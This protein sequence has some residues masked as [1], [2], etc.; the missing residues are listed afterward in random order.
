MGFRVWRVPGQVLASLGMLTAVGC[1]L[2]SG[3]SRL[4]EVQCPEVCDS[5]GSQGD[6]A[7]EST[8]DGADETIVGDS[9]G[10]VDSGGLADRGEVADSAEDAGIADVSSELADASPDGRLVDAGS[11][12]AR[13]DGGDSSDGSSCRTDLSNIGTADFDIALT[14][15]TTQTGLVALVNQRQ[16]CGSYNYWWDLRIKNG[17]ILVETEAVNLTSTAI[18]NDGT[19]HKVSVQRTNGRVWIYIDGLLST[20]A[21]L[22]SSIGQLPPLVVGTDPC[23]STTAPFAGKVADLC[24]SSP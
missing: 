3:L 14:V 2:A 17:T 21:V 19:S 5:G 23:T 10:M 16:R 24:L 1:A 7:D 22:V 15:T 18:V 13:L 4:E 6:G 11:G 8:V 12:D 9:A 20:S